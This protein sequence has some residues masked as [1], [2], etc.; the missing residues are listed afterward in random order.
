MKKI[1]PC[2]TV[3]RGREKYGT[4]LVIWGFHGPEREVNA[5][6]CKTNLIV[7]DKVEPFLDFDH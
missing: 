1:E 2:W 4:E 6:K 3:V 7:S 5:G